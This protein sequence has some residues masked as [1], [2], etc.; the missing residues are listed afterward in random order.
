[1]LPRAPLP[2]EDRALIQTEGGYDR[3]GRAAEASRVTTQ[4]KSADRTSDR[5][6]VPA[7]PEKGLLADPARQRLRK[8]S[9]TFR[10]LGSDDAS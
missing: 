9:W 10:L 4:T 7:R 1:M 3:L 2:V 5:E 8:L 6:G